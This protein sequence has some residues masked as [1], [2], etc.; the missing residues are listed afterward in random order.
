MKCPYCGGEME[1][2]TLTGMDEVSWTPGDRKEPDLRSL[3]TW[4]GIK[5][6]CAPS[7]RLLLHNGERWDPMTSWASARR[8]PRCDLFLFRG[9]YLYDED[10]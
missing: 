9:K 8:C 10:E 5:S 7:E 3:L 1:K 4:E 2:G 6:L